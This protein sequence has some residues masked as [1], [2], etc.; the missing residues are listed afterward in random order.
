MKCLNTV[1]QYIKERVEKSGAHAF[2]WIVQPNR[3]P[4]PTK[5]NDYPRSQNRLLHKTSDPIRRNL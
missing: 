5:K 2:L 1:L 4:A 3:N